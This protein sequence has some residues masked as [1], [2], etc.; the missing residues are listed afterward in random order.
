MRKG[1]RDT[2]F[3]TTDGDAQRKVNLDSARVSPGRNCLEPPRS[4]C[5]GT[6]VKTGFPRSGGALLAV[7]ILIGAAA[8]VYMRQPS[9]GFIA[10]LGVGLFLLIAVWLIDRG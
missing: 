9:I 8:G 3:E 10:G 5:H 7:S 6:R 4:A 1:I 2:R